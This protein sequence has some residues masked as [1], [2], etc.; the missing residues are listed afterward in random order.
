MNFSCRLFLIISYNAF[1]F[2]NICKKT[3]FERKRFCIDYQSIRI[4]MQEYLNF[5]LNNTKV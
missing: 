4:T 3:Q 1:H 2:E 5:F